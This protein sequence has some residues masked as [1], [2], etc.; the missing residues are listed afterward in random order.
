MILWLK[1]NWFVAGI[2][3]AVLLGFFF[4]SLA[5]LNSSGYITVGIVMMLFLSIGFS[6][7][8]NA[9][10]S[11][12]A[13]LK[14]HLFLQ[15]FIFI[16]IPAYFF[17]STALLGFPVHIRTGILALA[18]LP[19]TV[20]TCIVLTQAFGGNTV[21]AMFNAVLS[22][23]GGV[24]LAPMILSFL[25][26]EAGRSVPSDVLV[27]IIKGL[28]WKM[29]LPLITGLVLNLYLTE[30]VSMNK[31]RLGL[32][33]NFLILI[34]VLFS[35][36]R[37]VSQGDF[38]DNI[39]KMGGTILFVALSFYFLTALAYIF[40]KIFRFSD[41]DL[42]SLMFVGPQKTLAMGVPLLST[43]FADDPQLLGTVL[44]P[45]LFYHPWQIMNAGFLK[46]LPL[47]KRQSL[48]SEQM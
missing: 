27:G 9:L 37:S 7:P 40:G 12:L 39:D 22:N 30:K 43:Y 32:V 47:M 45:L 3:A 46:M 11:G 28:C 18:V 38:F 13:N 33:N 42:V 36:A 10:K 41:R 48:K 4:P 25:L 14:L 21:G 19:T 8:V 24:F 34:L 6:L 20:S 29:L 17:L 15:S 31:K 26:H 5:K 23:A 35:I 1:R 44:I 16:I 2:F